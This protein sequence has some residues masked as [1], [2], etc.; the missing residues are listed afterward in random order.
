M[1][2]SLRHEAILSED[3]NVM[4]KIPPRKGGLL[5]REEWKGQIYKVRIYILGLPPLNPFSVV[6]ESLF[7]IMQGSQVQRSLDGSRVLALCV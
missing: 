3:E 4:S 7:D 1:Q 6:S 2:D 5:D